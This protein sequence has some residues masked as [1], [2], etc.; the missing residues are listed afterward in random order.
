MSNFFSSTTNLNTFKSPEKLIDTLVKLLQ[1]YLNP[2]LESQKTSIE[3]QLVKRICQIK[4][5]LYGD[6]KS[7]VDEDRCK[8]VAGL[9]IQVIT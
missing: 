4:N 8:E 1:N 6:S 2:E 3:P 7:E 9:S 5:L